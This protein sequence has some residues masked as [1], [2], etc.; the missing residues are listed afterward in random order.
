MITAFAIGAR[1]LLARAGRTVALASLL[2]GLL[3]T[4]LLSIGWTLPHALTAGPARENNRYPTGTGVLAEKPVRGVPLAGFQRDTIWHG[5]HISVIG[6]VSRPGAAS[7]PGLLRLPPTDHSTVSPALREL[8]A[9]TGAR[10][11]LRARIPDPTST[12]SSSGLVDPQELFAYVGLHA[13]PP[14]S[15]PTRIDVTGW[16]LAGQQA[17][18]S[19]VSGYVAVPLIALI[20]L[21][22]LAL[23]ACLLRLDAQSRRQRDALLHV[24]GAS[25]A[26]RVAVDAGLLWPGLVTGW[27]LAVLL[28]RVFRS[29]FADQLFDGRL[30]FAS[31][32]DGGAGIFMLVLLL[33]LLMTISAAT[34]AVDPDDVARR[35]N[36]V[37]GRGNRLRAAVATALVLLGVAGTATLVRSPED[38]ALRSG[39]VLFGSAGLFLAGVLVA[40]PLVIVALARLAFGRS[41]SGDL[42]HGRLSA[43]R[44]SWRSAAL[45]M[46]LL[47]AIG[48]ATL[49]VLRVLDVASENDQVIW[50]PSALSPTTSMVSTNASSMRSLAAAAQ[51][52]IVDPA[53]PLSAH[54]IQTTAGQTQDRAVAIPCEALEQVVGETDCSARW[55]ITRS[56]APG[57]RIGTWIDGR[58]IRVGRLAAPV[59]LI[60]GTEIVVVPETSVEIAQMLMSVPGKVF[61]HGLIG[62]TSASQVEALRNDLWN[63]PSI[64]LSGGDAPLSAVVTAQDYLIDGRSYRNHYERIVEG[65][66][67]AASLIALLSMAISA[68]VDQEETE[69]RDATLV[70]LGSPP[71]TLTITRVGSGLVPPLVGLTIGWLTGAALGVGYL[72]YSS[73]PQLSGLLEGFPVGRYAIFG[74]AELLLLGAIVGP[75]LAIGS[76]RLKR[77]DAGTLA[78]VAS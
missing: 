62:T 66:L 28:S 60:G 76:I 3:A 52:G 2:F 25:R 1:A 32:L 36:A 57:S 74:L 21:P 17:F 40:L 41:A 19:D 47:G 55:V 53:I 20:V 4:T 35:L 24:L 73:Y 16:G 42:V 59:E 69:L 29:L 67:A 54:S 31:D 18:R 39:A 58:P 56:S 5:Y 48:G 37:G 61:M 15:D 65:G 77:V 44:A 78:P 33:L 22:M 72:A 46:L 45:A 13:A 70:C 49:S 11:D 23:A 27:A 26:K 7:P 51:F 43:S 34:S 38:S 14:P 71:S 68:L 75:I 6:I 63:K 64:S 8:M 9:D 12:I 10:H 30:G 50:N